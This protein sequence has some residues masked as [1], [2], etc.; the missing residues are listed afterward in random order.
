MGFH[1]GQFSFRFITIDID[2][3]RCTRAVRNAING[4]DNKKRKQE[5]KKR[6]KR[7][8]GLYYHLI[9]GR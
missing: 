7:S 8:R 5:G 1:F 2:G 6:E 3:R 4:A 9:H